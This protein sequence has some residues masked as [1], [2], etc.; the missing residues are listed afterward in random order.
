MIFLQKHFKLV[1]I[2]CLCLVLNMGTH[3][4][5]VTVS[6]KSPA[7]ANNTIA[8]NV[9]HDFISEE[10]I[11]LGSINFNAEG[12]FRLQID[13]TEISLCFAD[14][15]GYHGMIYLEP[16]KS[17][18]LVFPPKRNQ[19]EGQ[20]RNPFAKPEPVWLGIQNPVVDELNIQIQQFEQAYLTL[21]NKHF[22]QIFIN[23][24]KSLV[25]T[26]K[27]ALDKEFKKTDSKF[28]EYHKQFRKANLEFALHQG[29]AAG[30]METY[31]AS[32]KPIY[33]LAAYSGLFNQVFMNYFNSLI[34]GS[35]GADL[36][37]M[38]NSA[39][40]QQ[41]DEYFQKELHY[42]RDLAHLILL[43]AMKDGYYSNQFSKASI[44]KMLAQV[45]NLGWSNYEI[46]IAEKIRTKLTY[47]SSGTNPPQLLL[48]DS[49]G[50]RINFS[51]FPNT[52][53]YLHFTD[54]ENPV[55]R[56]HLDALKPIAGNYK[57][58]LIIIHVIQNLKTFKNEN[59]WPGIFTT[60]MNNIDE[61]YKVKTFPT[62]FLIGK[63]GKLLLSPAPNPIDGLDRQLGQIFKRDYFRE[64]QKRN[65]PNAK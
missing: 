18:E 50:Q 57:E 17:Y 20:K 16:G 15:D 9:L 4:A 33:N 12:S 7:Y 46:Q 19:T 38:I 36:K 40:L 42:N 39:G 54:P 65:Q 45:K 44:L 8:L 28:V 2:A 3:A 25:D 21:E 27:N 61:V 29:K 51:D 43:K 62:A 55:C 64:M 11:K 48:K 37:K 26:V 1:F 31:F 6:G 14:F 13:L 58:K 59:S 52:Y 24:S 32:I 34:L 10:K 22:T 30:F 60:S 47:L 49:N 35:N 23:Q 53:I 41:L 5:T 63:D 56:Q